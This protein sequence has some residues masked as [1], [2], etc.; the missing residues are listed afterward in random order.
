MRVPGH[1]KRSER[2]RLKL[3]TPLRCGGFQHIEVEAG[4]RGCRVVTARH[5][6]SSTS[7]WD[8]HSRASRA[9]SSPSPPR[10]VLEAVRAEIQEFAGVPVVDNVL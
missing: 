4:C 5:M 2:H 3:R 6:M 8:L 9:S 10:F 7:P 1:G